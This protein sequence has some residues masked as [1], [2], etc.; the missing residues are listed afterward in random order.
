M[1]RL[2]TGLA[3][4]GAWG[5]FDEFNRLAE[6]TLAAVADQFSSLLAATVD[7]NPNEKPVAL[8]NNKQV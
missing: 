3:L 6:D 4:T 5:C 1:G 8:L 7:R 2:L